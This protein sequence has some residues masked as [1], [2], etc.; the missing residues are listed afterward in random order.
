MCQQSIK[1]KTC[2]KT[3]VNEN[4]KND[5][6]YPLDQD[7]ETSESE[8]ITQ[9]SNLNI[10]HKKRPC[11]IIVGDSILKHLLGKSIAD[12]TSSD[13]IILVKPFLGA[14]TKAMK[15]YVSSD[16][17]KKARPTYCTCWH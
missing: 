1:S 14:R 6:S 10:L 15:H 8:E 13:N 17:E 3:S 5:E 4:S 9:Q 12:K 2:G 16:L 7:G 11:T